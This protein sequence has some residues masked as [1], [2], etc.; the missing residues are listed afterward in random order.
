MSLQIVGKCVVGTGVVGMGRVGIGVS[1]STDGAAAFF[2][3]TAG[4]GAGAAGVSTS[5]AKSDDAVARRDVCFT[6]EAPASIMSRPQLTSAADA[7][8][9]FVRENRAGAATSFDSGMA[10]NDMV[11]TRVT[12]LERYDL[13]IGS[14]LI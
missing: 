7:S 8:E 13:E 4:A 10:S 12:T 2:F 5:C 1:Q 11:I 3:M 14:L 9:S 6:L